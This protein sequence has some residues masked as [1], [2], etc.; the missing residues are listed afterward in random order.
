M[1]SLLILAACASTTQT[2][3]DPVTSAAGV[4]AGDD[5]WVGFCLNAKPIPWAAANPD[6]QILAI[7]QHNEKGHLHCGWPE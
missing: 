7:K 6:K 1:A 3:S 4:K 5:G 2:N